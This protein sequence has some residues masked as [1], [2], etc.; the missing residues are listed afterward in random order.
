MRQKYGNCFWKCCGT[1]C[2]A[3]S[4]HG[5]VCTGCNEACGKVFHADGKACPI[6]AC[7]VNKHRFTNCAS[8]DSVPCGIW[9]AT[10]DPSM[11]DEQFRKSI[12]DRVSALKSC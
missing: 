10:R 7:C 6:Y 9:Q 8:C 3:C 1:E 4:L 2:S 11:T 12:E 5:S